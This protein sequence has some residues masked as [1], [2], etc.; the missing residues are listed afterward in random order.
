MRFSDQ[1]IDIQP[2]ERLLKQK[3]SKLEALN[4]LD[5][6]RA[7]KECFR[8]LDLV[9][10]FKQTL[11]PSFIVDLVWHELIL[12]TAFYR[13]FCE[14][15]YDRFIH[16]HPDDDEAKNQSQYSKTLKLYAIRYG[17]PHPDFW[18]GGESFDIQCGACSN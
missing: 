5:H 10:E 17:Q 11:T 13:D 8:F 18:P 1:P 6:Q 16:H 15:R 2:I 14:S 3:L 7:I 4:G 12:F 9:G